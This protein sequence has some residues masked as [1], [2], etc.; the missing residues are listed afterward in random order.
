MSEIDDDSDGILRLP[1]GD[2][3]LKGVTREGADF[4]F[5]R[6]AHVDMSDADFYWGM[7]H[8][9]VLEGAIMTRI[10]LRGATLNGA[11]LRGADL[12]QAN[13]GLDNLGGRTDFIAW[14]SLRREPEPR[15]DRGGGLHQLRC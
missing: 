10:D 12:T 3:S 1:P 15:R 4:M 5:A 6:L 13:C 9:A 7:F 8:D 2:A 11:N 14:R